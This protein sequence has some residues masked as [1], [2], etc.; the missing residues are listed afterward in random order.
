MMEILKSQFCVEVVEPMLS[1]TR[2]GR[3]QYNKPIIE[4]SVEKD[5]RLMIDH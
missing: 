1:L 2:L 3:L 5:N 4:I